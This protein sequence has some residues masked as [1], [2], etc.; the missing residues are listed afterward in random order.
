MKIFRLI[1]FIIVPLLFACHPKKPEIFLPEIPS[2]LLIQKLEQRRQSFLGLKALA[3][4]DI[5]KSGRKR[6]YDTVGVM[7]DGQ[8]RLRVEAYGPLGQSLATL[9]WDGS[10]VLLRRDDGRVSRPGQAGLERILGITMEAGELCAV[11]SGNVPAFAQPAE[12]RAYREPDGGSLVE[13]TTADMRRLLHVAVLGSGPGQSIW[14]TDAEL[15]RS[16]KLVYRARYGQTETGSQYSIPKTILIENPERNTSL[17]VAYHEAE[18]NVLLTD[19][20]FTL[21]GAE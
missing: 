1:P 19:E 14:I 7:L 10:E 4:V 17:A 15:Y 5:F 11:L 16:G 8:R 3:G 13:I 20:V 6:A 2:G 9:I 12:T 18:V 21:P